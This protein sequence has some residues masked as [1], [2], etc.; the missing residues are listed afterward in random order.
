[1]LLKGEDPDT[2]WREKGAPIWI[3]VSSPRKESFHEALGL[4][5]EE[6]RKDITADVLRPATEVGRGVQARPLLAW[7]AYIRRPRAATSRQDP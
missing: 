1:M 2:W 7:V 5:N 6:M 3:E 4:L